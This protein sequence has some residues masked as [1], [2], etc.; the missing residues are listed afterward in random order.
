MTKVLYPKY[1]ELMQNSAHTS[2]LTADL[3]VGLLTNAYT[4]SATH[5]KL[6]DVA[7][8]ARV[9]LASS[10]LTSVTT[11][12]GLLNAADYA[13]SSLSGSTV[14]RV[15]IYELDTG[16]VEDSLLIYYMDEDS[17]GSPMST[18]PS[19][20]TFTVSIGSGLFKVGG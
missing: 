16:D 7:G 2:H 20:G 10:A 5:T 1:G 6:S 19:G 8:G 13:F 14:Q 11:T 15:V 18:T 17:S 12:D 3:R 4:Y 9:G